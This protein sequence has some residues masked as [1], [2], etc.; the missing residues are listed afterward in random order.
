MILQ[1]LTQYFLC[2]STKPIPYLRFFNDHTQSFKY[3]LAY[4][5]NFLRADYHSKQV[6]TIFIKFM[7]LQSD[8]E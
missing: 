6:N 8:D 4:L 7:Y 1:N 2:A 5:F 3:C